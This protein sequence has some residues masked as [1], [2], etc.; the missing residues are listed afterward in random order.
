MIHS[1][2]KEYVTPSIPRREKVHIA[3]GIVH[4]IRTMHPPGRFLMME[5][6]DTGTDGRWFDIGHAKAIKKS[7]QA[8]RENALVPAET[9]SV[10]KCDVLFGGGQNTHAH[11]GN[12]RCA[13]WVKKHCQ[14]YETGTKGLKTEIT[15]KFVNKVFE[16]GGRF[17]KQDNKKIW[18]EVSG[19][20]AIEKIAH[21]FRRLPAQ[22]TTNVSHS[23]DHASTP[24]PKLHSSS[25]RAVPNSRSPQPA[26]A[27]A[28]ATAAVDEYSI[29]ND[30]LVGPNDVICGRGSGNY[31]NCGNRRFHVLIEV[32]VETYNN[33]E[34]KHKKG[35]FILSLIHT[36]TQKRGGKFYQVTKNNKTFTELTE[37]QSRAKVRHA[38]RDYTESFDKKSQRKQLKQQRQ[39]KKQQQKKEKK[40]PQHSVGDGNRNDTNKDTASVPKQTRQQHQQQQRRRPSLV[41]QQQQQLLPQLSTS[42]L[43]PPRVLRFTRTSRKDGTVVQQVLLVPRD[44]GDHKTVHD[45]MVVA[46]QRTP[47]LFVD[48]GTAD[49]TFC[50][51]YNGIELP[52]GYMADSK[53]TIL[54]DLF[55]LTTQGT[56]LELKYSSSGNEKTSLQLR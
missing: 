2:K 52:L 23:I 49:I 25:H 35:I 56:P 51:S 38:L 13:A 47:V 37:L 4:A 53:H 41:S 55:D 19:T 32:N 15:K 31:K 9:I 44:I 22:T 40:Q 20:M 27:T 26:A 45:A 39:H 21:C 16:S 30:A 54:R 14:E 43:P 11:T 1:K 7:K 18:K 42:T 24:T 12:L 3:T 48:D 28:T 33:I 46:Q 8:L 34:S 29:T 36:I 50:Y 17:L 6:A 5:D 10:N